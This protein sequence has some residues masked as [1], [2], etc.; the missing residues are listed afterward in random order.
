[1]AFIHVMALNPGLPHNFSIMFRDARRSCVVF[2]QKC[3]CVCSRLVFSSARVSDN[4]EVEQWR[5]HHY[6]G[7]F[8]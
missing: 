6:N 3:V 2:S 7:Q 4:K 5:E 1:M 8:M